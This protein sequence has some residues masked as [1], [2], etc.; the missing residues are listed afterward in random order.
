MGFFNQDPHNIFTLQECA[1]EVKRNG[2]DSFMHSDVIGVCGGCDKA[3]GGRQYPDV[4][5]YAIDGGKLQNLMTHEEL[6]KNIANTADTINQGKGMFDSI[7]GDAKGLGAASAAL[8]AVMVLI[9]MWS[10]SMRPT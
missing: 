3:D 1:S 8:G 6:N 9:Q 10:P 2:Y 4:N 5:V 7:F